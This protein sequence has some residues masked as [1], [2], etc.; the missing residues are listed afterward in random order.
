LGVRAEDCSIPADF[1]VVAEIARA[2]ELNIPQELW[3]LAEPWP[4]QDIHGVVEEET[5]RLYYR[6]GISRQG[7]KKMDETHSEFYRQIAMPLLRHIDATFDKHDVVEHL[8]A[9]CRS[10]KMDQATFRRISF[11]WFKNNIDGFI[12]C[13][14]RTAFYGGLGKSPIF[15]RMLEAYETGGFP[16][17][18]LGPLPEDGG[19]PVKAIAVLHLG[20]TQEPPTAS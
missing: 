1:P 11:D 3:D 19:D 20:K 12:T 10:E 5:G 16:C 14:A 8:T 6:T 15:T 9:T 2:V 4:Y 13:I 18:W 17:G 7:L